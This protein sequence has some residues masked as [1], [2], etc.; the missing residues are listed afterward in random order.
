MSNSFAFLMP[1]QGSQ[2]VGLLADLASVFPGVQETFAEASDVLSQDLWSLCQ[3]G[4]ADQINQTTVTQP[5][6]LIADVAVWRVWQQQ[7][8]RQ[9]DFLARSQ[10]G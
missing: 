7:S 3:T 5:L 6:M 8:G 1:G 10:F 2:S 9:P 4:P